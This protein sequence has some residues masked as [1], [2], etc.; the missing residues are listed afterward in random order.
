MKKI[1]VACLLVAGIAT[2]A[3]A[4]YSNEFIKVGQQAPDL[5]FTNPKGELLKLSEINKGRIVLLDFWA[6]WCGPCR[7]ANPNLVAMWNK[8]KDQKFKG[9]K[10][11]FTIISISLDQ[12]KDKWVKAIMDDNL[13]WEYH[14]SDLGGWNSKPATLY[15]VQYIPQAFLVDADGK[16]LGKYMKAEEAEADIQKLVK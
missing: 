5:Q 14:M 11:G 12:D 3:W 8:M 6:S 10:N 13:S 7:R 9:A 2:A 4:Q 15:G 16:I 1:F